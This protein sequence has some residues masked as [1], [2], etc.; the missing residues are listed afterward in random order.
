MAVNIITSLATT[1]ADRGLTDDQFK[2]KFDETPAA[3]KTY[4]NDTLTAELDTALGLKVS[5]ASIVNDLTTGGTTVPLSAEQGKTLNTGK[6]TV[7]TITTDSTSTTPTQT[8]ASNNEYRF[9]NA[10]ITTLGITIPSGLATDFIA[11]V[12]WRNPASTATLTVTNSSGLTLKNS[13]DGVSTNVFTPVVSTTYNMIFFYDGV[14][15]NCVIRG[16]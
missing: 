16:A 11:S 12:V 1:S 14:N 15:I 6:A 7:T 5:T 13:G 3:I 10:A 2:A 9:T 4:L 8:L